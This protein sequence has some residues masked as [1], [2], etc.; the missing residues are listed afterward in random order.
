MA[1]V[2]FLPHFAEVLEQVVEAAERDGRL[3]LEVRADVD[4]AVVAG[5][6][7]WFAAARGL[8]LSCRPAGDRVEV[9]T[10]RT[11]RAG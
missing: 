9:R 11:R 3:D 1:E 10:A 7:R 5:Q 2:I 6:V 4:A 8:T